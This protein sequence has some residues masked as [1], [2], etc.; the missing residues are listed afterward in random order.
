TAR[1]GARLTKDAWTIRSVA[2]TSHVTCSP[3]RHSN[4]S[5]VLTPDDAPTSMI[6][7]GLSSIAAMY[8]NTA[9]FRSSMRLAPVLL[10]VP[11]GSIT[12]AKNSRSRVS[13]SQTS[14]KVLPNTLRVVGRAID[15]LWCRLLKCL[16][17]LE[18]AHGSACCSRRVEVSNPRFRFREFA[19]R[20]NKNCQ[21][22]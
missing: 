19:R 5:R 17:G 1:L 6:L 12:R 22:T 15:V 20:R 14:T 9:A 4:H 21:G 3:E 18:T 2:V 7:T 8:G 10:K 11:F 16:T 13:C